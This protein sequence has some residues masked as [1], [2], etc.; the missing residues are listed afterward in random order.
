MISETAEIFNSRRRQ[1]GPSFQPRQ[2]IRKFKTS[3]PR[4]QAGIGGGKFK[5]GQ[6]R[7]ARPADGGAIQRL[8]FAGQKPADEE[9]QADGFFGIVVDNF[10]KQ[11]ADGNF[12][13]EF[14]ADF[15]DEAL[16]KSFAGFQLAAGKFPQSAEMRF[17]VTS[18]D[19]QFSTA[20]NERGGNCEVVFSF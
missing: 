2:S 14:L 13:A 9:F 18:G 16:L 7:R 11:F 6:F 19:K 17:G 15:A 12:H 3:Q 5:P 20:K 4:Q 10:L 8:R 1:A